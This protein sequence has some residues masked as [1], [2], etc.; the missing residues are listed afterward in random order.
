MNRSLLTWAA[1]DVWGQYS[2]ILGF[3]PIYSKI[4][5]FSKKST[6]L[7]RKQIVN[8]SLVQE[9]FSSQRV[10][11]TTSSR[12]WKN[13]IFLAKNVDFRHANLKQSTFTG[14]NFRDSEFFQTTLTECDFVGATEFN[15]DLNSNA[16]AGA[17]FERFEALNLLTSLNIELCD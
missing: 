14:S 12:E 10:T 8:T 5:D 11:L 9:N 3:W 16:L 2:R 17:K 13:T 4:S 15:I 7:L 6:F 1:A